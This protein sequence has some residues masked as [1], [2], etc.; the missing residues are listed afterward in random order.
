M[1]SLPAMTRGLDHNLLSVNRVSETTSGEYSIEEFHEF[2]P[3]GIAI[4]I[5]SGSFLNAL[6]LPGDNKDQWQLWNEST[7]EASVEHVPIGGGRSI[8]GEMLVPRRPEYLT[9]Q[10]VALVQEVAQPALQ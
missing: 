10:G 5:A 8:H 1:A 4:T 9:Q 2:F 6:E 7:Q 3:K